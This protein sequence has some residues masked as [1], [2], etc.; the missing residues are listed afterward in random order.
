M[1]EECKTCGC[2]DYER[3]GCTMPSV[4]EIYACPLYSERN[5]N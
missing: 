5:E 4:D 3:E 1:P 2:W